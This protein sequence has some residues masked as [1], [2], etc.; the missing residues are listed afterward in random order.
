[1]AIPLSVQELTSRYQSG[2][3]KP[4]DVIEEVLARCDRYP[5]PAVWIAR[6]SREAV[7]A[8]LQTATARRNAGT[9]QSLLGIPFAIKDNIDFAGLPTT[10][11]C[12]AFAYRPTRSATVVQRLLDAGAIAI[13]KTNMDQF[14]TG[15]VGTRSPYGAVRNVF[16]DRFIAGG[17]SSGSAVAVAAGLVSFALGTDT[18]GSGRVP[19]AF[20]NIVGIKPTRGW[21]SARGVVPACQSLDCVSIFALN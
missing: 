17:S 21:L 5:D 4:A 20:N 11:A 7:F 10:A 15:L 16:D 18:A 6:C 12:P 19:A 13:G 1:M 8:Q 9:P 14:A 2:E 3:L